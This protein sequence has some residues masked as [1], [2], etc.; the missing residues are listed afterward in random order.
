MA[1]GSDETQDAGCETSAQGRGL[2]PQFQVAM[3]NMSD[4]IVVTRDVLK[5]IG[6]DSR[7]SIL[8]SLGERQKTQ[9]ELADE[10]KLSAPTIL[11]H[12]ERLV[13]A[14]LVEKLEEG[15]KWKYYRLTATGKRITGKSPLNVVMILSAALFFALAVFLLIAQ[16]AALPVQKATTAFAVP[17]PADAGRLQE[18]PYAPASLEET[19]AGALTAAPSVPVYT[20]GGS[21]QK[22][23]TD[24]AACIREPP[25]IEGKAGQPPSQEGI[26]SEFVLFTL[27]IFIAGTCAGYLIRKN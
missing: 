20:A 7:V 12:L 18:N 27:A 8:K 6:A 9:S 23:L 3:I 26:L 16:K 24:E 25:A 17:Q 1:M 14:G 22:N 19:G 15:R 10:L 2:W 5:A 13:A 4:E 11:E 21:A